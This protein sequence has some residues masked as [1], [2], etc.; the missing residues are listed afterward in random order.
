MGIYI[1]KF[2]PGSKNKIRQIG[3]EYNETKHKHLI[4]IQS[5]KKVL[6]IYW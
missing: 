4:L 1:N 6:K 3:K 5:D 2:M